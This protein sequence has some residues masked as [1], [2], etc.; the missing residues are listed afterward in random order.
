MRLREV[1]ALIALIA[2][3]VG[4][5]VVMLVAVP[6]A[7]I[8]LVAVTLVRFGIV[9]VAIVVPAI[10]VSPAGGGLIC[11]IVVIRLAIAL[12]AILVIVRA[13]ISAA[14][15][16][17]DRA[18]AAILQHRADQ[19]ALIGFALVRVPEAR[20]FSARSRARIKRVAVWSRE[21]GPTSK[22]WRSDA[23]AL[24]VIVAEG[25]AQTTRTVLGPFAR[26][27]ASIA[28][29]FPQARQFGESEGFARGAARLF[30]IAIRQADA[31]S[32]EA[33]ARL[34]ITPHPPAA[35][36]SCGEAFP[37]PPAYASAQMRQTGRQR[38]R[39]SR[40]KS[41]AARATAKTRASSRAAPHISPP[42][43]SERSQ[44]SRPCGVP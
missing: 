24:L 6:I 34:L 2:R 12:V 9:A 35:E 30:R 23:T 44:R 13:I 3:V 36:R 25:L 8:A 28:Q 29:A 33:H 41:R 20:R 27:L 32:V 7:L 21:V 42:P 17:A 18:D 40:C 19:R 15:R 11:V 37:S 39:T 43:R 31:P 16:F 38:R 22:L 14:R 4:L 10:A 26:R 5:V 1:A